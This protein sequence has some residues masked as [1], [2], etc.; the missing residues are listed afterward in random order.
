MLDRCVFKMHFNLKEAVNSEYVLLTTLTNSKVVRYF[1][2]SQN[3]FLTRSS[4]QWT[5]QKKQ[6]MVGSLS[7]TCQ[8]KPSYSH[9]LFT[10]FI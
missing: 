5:K 10:L 1:E 2:F 7:A 9:D 6:G 3:Q 8:R 4:K